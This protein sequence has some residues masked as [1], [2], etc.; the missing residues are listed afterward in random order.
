[1]RRVL[2]GGVLGGAPGVVIMALGFELVATGVTD[3][4]EAQIGV[5]GL[6][7]LFLGMIVGMMIGGSFTMD[8]GMLTCG[9][10][11]GFLVGGVLALV[12][13]MAVPGAWRAVMPVSVLAGG[14]AGAWWCE[15][16]QETGERGARH[17][18][19]D[20]ATQDRPVRISS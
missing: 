7:M 2:I 11:L 19:P 16:Q 6:P 5:I 17:Q 10:S 9:M 4:T 1:M 13:D 18:T 14:T 15:R 12:I 8:L 3:L 20:G